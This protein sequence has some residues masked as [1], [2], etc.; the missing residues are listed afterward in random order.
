M[1]AKKSIV[2]AHMSIAGGIEQA[3]IR[4]QSIGCNAI[5][6]FVKS[7]RQWHAAPL[8][9]QAIDL[10]QS[11]LKQSTIERHHVVVHAS[12]LIN[13]G[14]PEAD[15][16]NQSIKGLSDELMRCQQLD[17]PW[18]VLHPGSATD[19]DEKA[20]LTRIAHSLDTVFAQHRGHTTILLE[21]MAGQGNS[22]AYR[23]EQIAEIMQ[24]SAHQQR[25]GVCVD[26]C[27]LYA[28][29]YDISTTHGYDATWK[30]FD[31]II[32]LN[33]LGAIHLNDSKKT[34]GSRVD[35]HADIGAGT[36]GLEGFR[37]LMND[38]RFVHIPKILETPETDDAMQ[39]YKRNLLT[40]ISLMK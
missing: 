2:G 28:A 10:F 18:L 15:R 9:P 25:L 33:K 14:S 24:Q 1:L 5:Q 36:I 13:L 4:G 39:D 8:T 12:Y 19:G 22:V 35:R 21:T 40:L 30:E 11:T 32:G 20:C 27:H 3:I 38:K 23:F 29:G 37:L 26:T 16:R 31:E 6:I 7:N 17:I 34:L